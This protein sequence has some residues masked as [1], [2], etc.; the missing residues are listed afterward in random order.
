MQYIL[1]DSRYHIMYSEYRTISQKMQRRV[2]IPTPRLDTQYRYSVSIPSIDT[3]PYRVLPAYYHPEKSSTTRVLSSGKKDCA[4]TS[5]YW[6]LP[7]HCFWLD[8]SVWVTSAVSGTA[9]R[10]S[11]EGDIPAIYNTIYYY[12]TNIPCISNKALLKKINSDTVTQ[13][14]L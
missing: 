13:H 2:G 14:L 6:V 1:H 3:H 4:V 7:L 8:N 9:E 5:A 11:F 12:S 10:D